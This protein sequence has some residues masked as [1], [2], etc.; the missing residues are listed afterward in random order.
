MPTPNLGMGHQVPQFQPP[1]RLPMPMPQQGG[2]SGMPGGM[3]GF[4]GNMPPG[5]LGQI[6]R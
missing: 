1:N 4:P 6:Q 5:L 3:S 2:F